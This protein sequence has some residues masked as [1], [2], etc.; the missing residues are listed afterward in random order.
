MTAL[1]LPD[2]A[3]AIDREHQA[4][5][6]AART[7]LEHAL[8]CGRLLIQAKAAVPHGEWL[9]WLEANTSV[10]ARQSQRYMRLAHAAIEGKYDATSHLTIDEALALL[11]SPKV[12]PTEHLL[13]V[14]GSSE[15]SEWYTPSPIVERV[16]ATLGE[17]DLDPSWHPESPVR[18]S[19][20]FTI[21]DDGLAQSW[22]GRVYLNPPYGREIDDWI[23]KLVAEY[24]AGTVIEAIALV[25]ARVD[26]EWFRRLDRFPR[27][28]LHGRVTFANAENPAPFPTAIFYLGKNLARFV[29]AFGQVGSIFVRLGE[30]AR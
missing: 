28:F 15:T 23:E 19:A 16:V 4:A 22:A 7:A 30:A 3:Q 5:H 26:T 27:C 20:A 24:E 13:R 8:E 9:P 18:A 12:G 14:I 11:A 6:Q 17:V 1:A 10:S 29:E 21:A 2:L 25:P